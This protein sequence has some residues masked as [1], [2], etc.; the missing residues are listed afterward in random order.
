MLSKACEL[1]AADEREMT[2]DERERREMYQSGIQLREQR[3]ARERIVAVDPEAAESRQKRFLASLP[4]PSSDEDE[5]TADSK[6]DSAKK[7]PKSPRVW[8][9]ISAVNDYY[10]KVEKGKAN[11][12]PENAILSM[13]LDVP[14]ESRDVANLGRQ[15]REYRHLIHEPADS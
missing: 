10:R 7:T 12:I 2:A 1:E 5:R 4:E 9:A 14:V 3:L 6:S 8:K 13:H 11:K 15:L